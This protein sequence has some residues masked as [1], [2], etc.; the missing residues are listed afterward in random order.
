LQ[1]S[2][3]GVECETEFVNK[4]YFN[5]KRY[6]EI[7]RQHDLRPTQQRLALAEIL[8]GGQHRHATAE[9]LRGEVKVKGITM[10]LATIYN[11]LNQF[12]RVGLLREITLDNN[13][14]YFDTNTDHHHHFF[15]PNSSELIDIPDHE[16]GISN[17]PESPDGR[18][19]ERVDVV[20]RLSAK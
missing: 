7:L 4:R 5:M 15:D 6:T 8:F 1:F 9:K 10:S 17:L 20:I 3:L 14:T 19:V 16:I 11:T 13:V 2:V 18:K 12:T